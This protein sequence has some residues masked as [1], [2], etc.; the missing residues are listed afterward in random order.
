MTG[1]MIGGVT[2][3]GLPAELPIYVD[4]HV[5]ALEEVIMGGGDR[6]TKLM[7]SPSVFRRMPSV[8]IVTDL[9]KPTR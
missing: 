4:E 7:L 1:M 5:M 6:S 3:F 8:T 2:P 9:V